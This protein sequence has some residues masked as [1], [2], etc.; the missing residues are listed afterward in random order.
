MAEKTKKDAC[1]KKIKASYDDF[2]SARASQAIAKCRKKKGI[3]RK[4]EKGAKLKRWQKEKWKNQRGKDCGD[5]P[6]GKGY[7]RPTKRVSKKTPKTRSE[8]RKSAYRKAVQAK[9]RGE[10]AKSQRRRK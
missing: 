10:R 3:V 5:D 9:I 6:K 7:C 1:Y 8:I 4:S 2:P